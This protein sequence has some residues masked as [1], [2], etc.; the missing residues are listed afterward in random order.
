[1]SYF[2]SHIYDASHWTN[3]TGKSSI[4]SAISAP[5]DKATFGIYS[6][7]LVWEEGEFSIGGL[8]G[9]NLMGGSLGEGLYALDDFVNRDFPNFLK[10]P[11]DSLSA[12]EEGD[13]SL[14]Q[15]R[16]NWRSYWTQKKEEWNEFKD[17]YIQSQ[18]PFHSAA[19]AEG[20]DTTESSV[21]GPGKMRGRDPEMA[22]NEGVKG[23]GRSSLKIGKGGGGGGSTIGGKF[24]TYRTGRRSAPN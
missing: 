3:D 14:N 13:G 12:N 16:Q 9:S 5:L 8:G 15:F 20:D 21:K 6:N 22:F 7:T 17:D 4:A 2:S 18:V 11:A 10:F 1:M 19:G 23:Y 24:K